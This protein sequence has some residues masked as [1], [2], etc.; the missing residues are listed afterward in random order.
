MFGGG[1]TRSRRSRRTGCWT[2]QG[3]ERSR[4]A[5]LAWISGSTSLAPSAASVTG[6][7]TPGPCGTALIRNLAR[8]GLSSG[9]LTARVAQRVRPMP[10]WPARRQRAPIS[11]R[12]AASN[13]VGLSTNMLWPA[14]GTLIG[15]AMS[16]RQR[17][18]AAEICR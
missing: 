16:A 15:S 10:V 4:V 3:I 11:V 2:W 5:I 8:V 13:A 17:R 12:S 1:T 6:L 14:L 9:P 18:S 7:A